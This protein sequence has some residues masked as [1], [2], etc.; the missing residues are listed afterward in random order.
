LI[1]A[2]ND[3]LLTGQPLSAAPAANSAAVGRN[4]RIFPRYEQYH[5]EYLYYSYLIVIL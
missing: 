2:E 4:G 3:P 1:S 5:K